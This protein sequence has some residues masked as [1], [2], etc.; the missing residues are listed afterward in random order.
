MR[1]TSILLVLSFLTAQ[2]G[3][4]SSGASDPMTPPPLPED[5]PVTVA[6]TD[7]TDS[8][9][10]TAS[11][12]IDEGFSGSGTIVLDVNASGSESQESVGV[13]LLLSDAQTRMLM[14]SM[15]VAVGSPDIR[16]G[17]KY[18]IHADSLVREITSIALTIDESGISTL[19]MELGGVLSGTAVTGSATATI[20]GRI[21]ALC[22]LLDG[23]ADPRF[24]TAFCRTEATDLGLGP[25]LSP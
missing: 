18:V 9:R 17:F 1:R 23:R 11:L 4:S 24:E 10:G 15:P 5:Y 25:L 13:S 7:A 14:T 21:A 16:V 22:T 19:T 3:C 6:I 8:F 12:Q 20:H 2:S